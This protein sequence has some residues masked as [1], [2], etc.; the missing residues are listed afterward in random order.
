VRAGL[1]KGAGARGR[2][3]WPRIPATCVSAR[4]L[5]HGGRGGANRGGPRRSEGESERT[6]ATT[7]RL[8]NW[9]REV[10]RE[11]GHVGEETGADSLAPL[12]SE[13]EREGTREWELPLTSGSHLSGGAGARPGWAELGRLGCFA[14]FFF[15]RFS[16][17]FSISFFGV[18]NS[19]SNH[20]SNSTNSNMCNN[21]KTIQLSMMQHV[22]TIVF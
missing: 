10:E 1:K 11:E 3:S 8:A 20:V 16:N 22:M 6:G 15:S 9:A 4:A 18:F 21:S 13:R 2:A 12:G 19:N 17:C 14:L 5:V 7:R